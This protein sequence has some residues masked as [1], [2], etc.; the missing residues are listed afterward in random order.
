VWESSSAANASAVTSKRTYGHRFPNPASSHYQAMAD[1][2][3][4]MRIFRAAARNFT[5]A[6][7]ALQSSIARKRNNLYRATFLRHFNYSKRINT[8]FFIPF[9]VFILP[10]QHFDLVMSLTD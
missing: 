9:V 6:P 8:I 2:V 3:M 7:A 4:L 10:G 1:I 5:Q